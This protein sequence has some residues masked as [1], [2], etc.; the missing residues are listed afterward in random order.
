MTANVLEKAS[1][2]VVP[3]YFEVLSQQIFKSGMPQTQCR[4]P[5]HYTIKFDRKDV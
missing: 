1:E 5:N 2:E 3:G 4:S